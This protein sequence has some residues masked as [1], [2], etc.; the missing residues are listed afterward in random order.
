MR[1]FLMKVKNV[2]RLCDITSKQ[3]LHRI[4]MEFHTSPGSWK[5]LKDFL[6]SFWVPR[7][8]EAPY[9]HVVQI[10]DPVLRQK[11]GLVPEEDIGGPAV[12]FLLN[13]MYYTMH[14][15]KMSGIA[16]P[17]VGVP[18]RVI[19]MEF[20]EATL[21][22]YSKEVVKTRNMQAMPETVFVNPELKVTDYTKHTFP[23]GCGSV[24]GFTADVTRYNGVELSG[25]DEKG[26]NRTLK[27]EGWS[28]R[29]AQHEMDHLEGTMYIDI[30]KK[31][32]LQLDS[33]EFINARAGRVELKYYPK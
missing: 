1:N 12:K 22:K 16:A 29:I 19:L 21:K 13:R 28:A 33:W 30:M 7:T 24:M 25:F 23:E 17:Q 4:R 2:S 3:C 32:S 18:L 27:L 8:V 26:V 6:P 15:F 11:A 5:S 9:K 31:K 10:G 14:A 20:P